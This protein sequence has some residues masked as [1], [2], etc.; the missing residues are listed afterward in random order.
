MIWHPLRLANDGPSPR[1][2]HRG[3]LL[4]LPGARQRATLPR[5][6][7][8]DNQSLRSEVSSAARPSLE[9]ETPVNVTRR[10]AL[11]SVSERSN[12][13]E[14]AHR[15]HCATADT[16]TEQLPLTYVNS[17]PRS[18]PSQF[19]VEQMLDVFEIGVPLLQPGAIAHEHEDLIQE[20]Q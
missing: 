13:F 6:E 2:S 5:E 3:Y 9:V 17:G 18:D 7:R 10:H 12:C 4:F 20:M 15:A 8:Y 14:G 1:V 19:R 16:L 11:S